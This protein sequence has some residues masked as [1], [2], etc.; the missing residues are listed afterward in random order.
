MRTPST[1][2]NPCLLPGVSA[3]LPDTPADTVTWQVRPAALQAQ[4]RFQADVA[5]HVADRQ[6]TTDRPVGLSKRANNPS[7]AVHK[8]QPAEPGGCWRAHARRAR[9]AAAVCS[10]RRGGGESP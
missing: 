1:V 7:P 3:F 2:L 4:P 9:L 5:H 6:R 8:L 10:C